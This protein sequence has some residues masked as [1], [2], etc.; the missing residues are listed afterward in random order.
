MDEGCFACGKKFDNT[1][2]GIL[3]RYK[4]S[5]KSFWFYKIDNGDLKIIGNESFK[6]FRK[7][8]KTLF[9]SERVEFA[10]ISEFIGN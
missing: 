3:L 8:N 4:N 2:K 5:G 10:H 7:D 6:Q 9:D 1:E